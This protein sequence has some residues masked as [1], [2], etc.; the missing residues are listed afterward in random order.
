MKGM[1]SPMFSSKRLKIEVTLYDYK[2]GESLS[3]G[4]ARGKT[5]IF[6]DFRIDCKIKKT[7]SS[8]G[9]TASVDIY[10]VS[11]EHLEQMTTLAWL[12]NGFIPP[13]KI[14]IYSDEGEG[15]HTL[16]EGG[17]ME[18]VPV[19]KNVPDV[20]IHIESSMLVYPNLMEVPPIPIKTGT[21][22]PSFLKE[23]CGNYNIECKI[24]SSLYGENWK[25]GTK[26]ITGE[27]LGM[28]LDKLNEI[29]VAYDFMIDGIRFYKV[30]KPPKEKTWA[31][32]P[33]IYLGYP[34]FESYGICVETENT[35]LD[36]NW[37]D[38]LK[39]TGSEVKVALGKWLVNNIEY[40]LQARKPNGK[41]IM[42]IHAS[43]MVENG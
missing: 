12:S 39:I 25:G 13:R 19:Y 8:S 2:M 29:G 21:N 14:R 20:S 18:A 11:K 10:G 38:Y 9:Y 26:E 42:K 7:P 34:T 24:D 27:G 37:G 5:L 33:S 17:I 40:D 16:F 3:V 36:I 35:N 23:L 22:I 41:W 1:H 15:Y 4:F 43:R 31:L 6:D 30:G 32:N 28:R